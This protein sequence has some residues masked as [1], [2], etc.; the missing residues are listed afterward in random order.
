MQYDYLIVGQGLSGSL[1]AWFALKKGLSPLVI[2]QE[3]PRAASRVAAGLVN[4]ITGR[5]LVKTWRADE[6]L[7]FAL[8]TYRELEN[9]C[10]DQFYFEKNVQK[11][12]KNVEQQNEWLARS[13]NPEYKGY[14]ANSESPGIP[15][16]FLV[17][18]LGGIE[19]TYS[20]YLDTR[21]FL[22]HM[23]NLL[24]NKGLLLE[25]HLNYDAF[26]A[27][28]EGVSWNGYQARYLIFCE[29]SAVK[30]NPYFNWLPFSLVKGQIL[31]IQANQLQMDKILNKDFWL[32]PLGNGYFRAGS[33]YETDIDNPY[34]TQEGFNQLKKLLDNN[35]KVPYTVIDQQAGIRPATRD[36]RPFLGL[37]PEYRSI[38]MVNGM[39]SKGVSLA[40]F[41]TQEMV[42]FLE[43]EE[44]LSEK[45][46]IVRHL[47]R[48]YKG[49]QQ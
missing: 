16:E 22:S 17:N 5:R 36:V 42:R 27:N 41:F 1:L 35:L 3:D 4:P 14:V 38:G 45:V 43:G 13:A 32:I 34:P 8:K 39:G 33:T 48:F 19:I 20:G 24:K 9:K 44:E 6:I 15:E 7:P 18:E 46:N 25:E 40:P 2:D 47:K 28:S 10:Q 49:S 26:Q 31:T 11:V 23:R 37:H 12:F 29:G 30:D 21:T